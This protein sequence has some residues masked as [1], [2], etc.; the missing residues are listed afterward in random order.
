MVVVTI[1]TDEG[2]ATFVEIRGHGTPQQLGRLGGR[3]MHH[4]SRSGN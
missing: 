2:E 1:D 4:N 3:F